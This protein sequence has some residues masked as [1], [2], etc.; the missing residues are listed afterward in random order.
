M[1][2]QIE[3]LRVPRKGELLG[4]VDQL[5]GFDRIRVRC[6]DGY[7]RICRIPGKLRKRLWIREGDLVIVRPWEVQGEEKGD[8]VYRYTNTQVEWLQRKGIWS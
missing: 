5:V 3:R 2:E 7:V 6:K 1:E 8:V 4:V